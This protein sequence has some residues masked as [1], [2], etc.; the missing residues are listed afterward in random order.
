VLNPERADEPIKPA[1][2]PQPSWFFPFARE[3]MKHL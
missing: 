3:K 2:H 1:N